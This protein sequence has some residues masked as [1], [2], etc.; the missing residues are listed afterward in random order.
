MQEGHYDVPQE[1]PM[2]VVGQVVVLNH[3]HVA[4]VEAQSGGYLVFVSAAEVSAFGDNP[5]C[6]ICAEEA[7]EI[8]RWARS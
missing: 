1:V 8:E 4:V 7:Q 5:D 2:V 6:A 3:C